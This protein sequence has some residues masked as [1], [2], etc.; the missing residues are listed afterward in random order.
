MYVIQK[1]DVIEIL[2]NYSCELDVRVIDLIEYYHIDSKICMVIFAQTVN[3]KY[4]I[5]LLSKSSISVRDEEQQAIF[6]EFL[7]KNGIPIPRKYKYNECFVSEVSYFGNNFYITVEDYFGNDIKFITS[8]TAYVLGAMLAKMHS[9]SL[10]NNYHMKNGTTYN[11]LVSGKIKLQNIWGPNNGLL[12]SKYDYKKID[13]IHKCQIQQIKEIWGILPKGAVHGDLGLTSNLMLNGN[14]YGIIDF[15]LSGDEVFLN[16]ML[17]TWYS[18]RYNFNNVMSVSLNKIIHIR[19]NFFDAYCHNRRLQDIEY[20]NINKLSCIINGIYF[21]RFVANVVK[22]GY[23]TEK[24][25][26]ISMI[27][28]NYFQQDVNCELRKFLQ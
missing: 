28:K 15:N 7:R 6:S 10:D 12:M 13:E 19:E 14:K 20:E 18:S 8:S 5:K 26:L 24:N 27:E 25:V 17:V 9:I 2:K 21:N 3:K 22:K 16:D 23:V 4:I 1:K 11:A